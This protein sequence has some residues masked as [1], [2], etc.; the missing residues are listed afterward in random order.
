MA[1][2]LAGWHRLTV[3]IKRHHDRHAI[4]ADHRIRAC[5]DR[6]QR[7]ARRTGK[8]GGEKQDAQDQKAAHEAALTIRG[9]RSH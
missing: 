1:A 7:G 2:M 4:R 8:R 6:A 9:A 3:R 5:F